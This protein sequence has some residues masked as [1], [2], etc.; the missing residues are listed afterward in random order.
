M[1]EKDEGIRS[2]IIQIIKNRNR[3]L[4]AGE[5]L[6]NERRR[7]GRGLLHHHHHETA[8]NRNLKTM[9]EEVAYST[10]RESDANHPM[11]SELSWPKILNS[12]QIPQTARY[13]LVRKATS[14]KPQTQSQTPQ[15][16]PNN[17]ANQRQR[18]DSPRMVER[19]R[20]VVV[21]NLGGVRS[22]FTT[23]SKCGCFGCFA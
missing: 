14:R 1:G 12:I 11:V 21:G 15:P 22:E 17:D 2:S 3:E 19:E 5:A 7:E 9:K 20:V 10:E 13:R 18:E 23:N 16:K 6:P 4:T 8:N